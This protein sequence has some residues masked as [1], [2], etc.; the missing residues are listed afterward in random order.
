M[1]KLLVFCFLVVFFIAAR[2][3]IDRKLEV[4]FAKQ[5][6]EEERLQGEW[7]DNYQNNLIDD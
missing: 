1:T 7:F 5:V 2:K 3:Y 6:E 4:Y